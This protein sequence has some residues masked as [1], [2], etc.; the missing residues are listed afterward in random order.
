MNKLVYESEGKS[1]EVPLTNRPVSFGRSD[2]ADHPLPTK[3]A[4]R[5]HA[6]VFPRERAWWIE[7]LGSSNGTLVNGNKIAKPMPLVPGDVITVGDVKLTFHGDAAPDKGP[8]DHLIARVVFQGDKSKPPLETLIRDRITIG[9]KPDNTLQI[10]NKAVSGHHCELI[11]RQ[12][13]Y[14]LRDLGS[15]NGTY[16]SGKAVTEHTLRNGDVLML[17]KKVPVYF[18]DP[19]GQAAQQPA[20]GGPPPAQGQ[21]EVTPEHIPPRTAPKPASSAAGASDRGVFKPVGEGQAA[22]KKLNP[23]PHVGVGLGLALLFV[24]A[25]WLLGSVISGVKNRPKDDP[26]VRVPEAA[27]A[28]PA[29]SFEGEIDNGGNPEG[30]TASFEAA[31]GTKTELL[32]DPEDPFDGTRSL[33]V[34][35]ENMNGTGTLVLQTTQARKLDLGGAF[36]LSLCMKGE[37]ASKVAVALSALNEK[38]DVVTLAAG[39][40]VGIKGTSWQQFTMNGM[41]LNAPP[42]EAQLRLLI[43]GSFSRLWIDR[44]ELAKTV[45]DLATKPFRD[46][47]AP[48]LQLTFNDRMAAQAVVTNGD[49]RSARFQPVLTSFNDRQL[50]ESELWAVSAVK[51]D[52]VTYSAMM[53]SAGDAAAARVR[54]VGYSNGYFSEHGLRV[55]WEMTQGSASALAVQ[56]ILPMPPG[57]TI[58]VADRRGYPMALERNAIHAYPYSTISEL[59][60]NGSG[61]SVSFPRGAV[62]WFD[63]SQPG[64]LIATV[65]SAADSDRKSVKIDVNTR[66]L[67]FARLY[68]RLLD[69]AARLQEAEHYSAAEARLKYLTDPA[70]ADSDLPAIGTARK[71]L[72]DIA[73]HRV[74]LRTRTDDAWDAVQSARNKSSVNDAKS[75][76]MQYISQFPGDPVIDEMNKRLDSLDT[77]AAEM[78]LQA[79]PPEE[80]KIAETTAKQLYDAAD[81]SAKGQDPNLLLALVMLET[82]MREYADTSQYNNAKALKAEVERRLNDPAEQDRVIDKELAGIDEDIK[83]QDWNRGRKRCQDLFKRFPNSK[84]TRDIMKRL[85]TIENAFDG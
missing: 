62:V 40:F 51:P 71:R 75:L 48:N 42:Q 3:T 24:L 13:A 27:L 82:I 69:E 2:D 12:G 79:R 15:S 39:S 7:D 20:A 10:E 25:G 45:D 57:A 38:G 21:P 73:V 43:A 52:S 32:A 33:R 34:T 49:G 31:A 74:D 83:F 65:R 66:P 16:I 63:L 37:G 17:G 30:W 81:E 78:K 1:V 76:V 11:N 23:L 35:A 60:V 26:N 46:L 4:S 80:M 84:R 47:D 8:P 44:L 85:K 19:A 54:A 56:I 61:L 29:M 72:Q 36:Q 6:Q 55:E 5:I 68:E 70:R 58:A 64:E 77:W 67:M 28:D 14:V 59:M 18:I 53:P 9:R 50:S 22:K 41:T